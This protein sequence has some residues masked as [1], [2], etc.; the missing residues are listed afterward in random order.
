M[1]IITMLLNPETW[2]SYLTPPSF[3]L[4]TMYSNLNVFLSITICTFIFILRYI[5]YTYTHIQT[6]THICVYIMNKWNFEVYLKK[7]DAIFSNF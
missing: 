5:L 1:Q 3:I 7:T 2:E 6:Y 4:L